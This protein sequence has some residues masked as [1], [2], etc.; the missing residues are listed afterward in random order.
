VIG[1]NLHTWTDYQGY[2]P[3][4]GGIMSRTDDFGYPNF[5]TLSVSIETIF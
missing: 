3:E 5:R 2:D 1:R 4:A